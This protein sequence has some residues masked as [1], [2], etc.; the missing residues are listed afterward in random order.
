MSPSAANEGIGGAPAGAGRPPGRPHLG[1]RAAPGRGRRASV[2]A[3]PRRW[4]TGTSGCTYAQLAPEV[5]RYA[6]GF[7][8]AGV[9]AG[10]RVAMWAP[11]CAEWMLAALGLLRAGAVLVPLEHPVQGRGGGVHHSRRRRLDVGHGA[12]L[13]GRRLPGHAGRPGHRRP[14]AHRAPARRRCGRRPSGGRGAV[15][16][17]GGRS[18]PPVRSVEPGDERGEGGRRAARRPSR[19]SSSRRARPGTPKVP[20]RRMPSRCGRSGPGRPSSGSPPATATSSSIRSST[21]S[22]TRRASSPA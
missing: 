21:P 3:A 16:R 5:D 19:T 1:H 17:S 8:A 9:G 20:Q 13:S 12:G 2:T 10:D 11:N 18:W 22:A 15:D 6:R 14:G 4:S 7:V